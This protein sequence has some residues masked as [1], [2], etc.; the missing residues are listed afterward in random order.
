MNIYINGR[1][2][3]HKMTGVQR[4]A[5]EITSRLTDNARICQP[6][7]KLRGWRGHLWEQTVLPRQSRDGILWS[8]CASGPVNGVRQVVTFH[9]LFPVDSPHWYK[10]AY[11]SWHGFIMRNLALSASRIIAVSE[12]TKRRLIERF[13]V[14]P[15]KITVIHNGV[16]S[17]FFS[18]SHAAVSGARAALQ[19]PPGKYLLSVGSL[20]PRK[21]LKRLMAAWE[22]V[23]AELPSDVWLVVS[24]SCDENVYK[25]AGLKEWPARVFLT[26]HVPDE[27]LPGLY[28]GSLG[29]VY[30]SLAEGFG[31][32][33][34]E[35][36]ACGVPVLTSD[37]T[38]LPEVCSSAALYFDPT[39]TDDLSRTIKRL[40]DNKD[41]QRKL[42]ILGR[43]RAA[44]FNWERAA[45]QTLHVLR[46]I[47]SAAH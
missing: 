11:A 4:V 10:P 14:D 38:A 28:A 21:N 35:A 30:P 15:S 40:V 27:H 22:N 47:A 31:L 20:E 5:H 25:N 8:P 16:D 23:A 36:M 43:E 33:P 9:D 45:E 46:T 2:R 37:A 42:S 19:L 41:L 6:Q 29:F 26:G 13:S 17:K 44:C 7:R 24:G 39:N 12:Y 34:L 32:P 3:S 18:T 1:F